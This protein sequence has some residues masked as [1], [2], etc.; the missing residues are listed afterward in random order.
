MT[1]PVGWKMLFSVHLSFAIMNVLKS[2]TFCFMKA[3]KQTISSICL[4][5]C[6]W[7]ENKTTTNV[8]GYFSHFISPMAWMTIDF[9][10]FYFLFWN[11][12][13]KSV[14]NKIC[15]WNHSN[16]IMSKKEKQI[17]ECSKRSPFPC[18]IPPNFIKQR[19]TAT[20]WNSTGLKSAKLL[21]KTT[22]FFSSYRIADKY[23]SYRYAFA[24]H[25]IWILKRKARD[26]GRRAH[27]GRKGFEN[28]IVCRWA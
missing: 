19:Q 20:V 25:L 12:I 11:S 21:I 14:N 18:Q 13:P 16:G 2:D 8:D 28:N 15:H 5:F 27:E 17:N 3:M 4:T 26:L 7:K 9:K 10:L 6:Q 23:G 1:H 22:L 24:I